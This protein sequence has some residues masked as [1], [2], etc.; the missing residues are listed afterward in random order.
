MLSIM[1]IEKRLQANETKTTFVVIGAKKYK[2]QMEKEITASPVMFGSLKC[3]PSQSEVY[4]GEVIHSEGL[5]AK[6]EATIDSRL[7]K[8]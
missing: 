2:E 7:G 8:V 6:L 5:E 1:S 4:L 3:K